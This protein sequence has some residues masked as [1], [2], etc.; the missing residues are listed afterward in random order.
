MNNNIS[1]NTIREIRNYFLKQSDW[2]QFDDVGMSDQEKN[3][4]KEYRLRLRDITKTFRVPTE[5]VW[6]ISPEIEKLHEQKPL[7]AI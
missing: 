1:W 6:P 5:V 2:T 3:K 7:S 4:W